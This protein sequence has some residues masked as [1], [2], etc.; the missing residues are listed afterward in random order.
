MIRH[1]TTVLAVFAALATVQPGRAQTPEQRYHDWASPTFPASEYEARRAAALGRL[2]GGVLLVPSSDGITHGDT[3][4]Q[5]DDFLYFTGLELP[6]SMLALDSDA[7]TV[8]LFLPPRDAR[9]ENPG[10]VNDFPGR[11]LGDDPDVAALSGITETR[12]V[13]VLPIALDTWVRGGSRLLVNAGATGPVEL[14]HPP[15][16]GSLDPIESLVMRVRSEFDG[17]DIGNAYPMLARLRM[18]KS[19]AEIGVMRRAADATAAGIR[20][21]A[22]AVGP[23]VDEATLQGIFEAT[24]R[25]HAAARIP[26]TPIVKSGPNSLWPWRILAAHSD[27]RNRTMGDGDVVILDVGCEVAGYVSDVGRSFP[28]SGRFTDVQRQKLEMITAVADAIIAAVRPGIRLVDLTNVA[29]DAIPDDEEVYMQTP[30]YFGHHIGLSSGDPALMDEIL[31]PGMVFT[32]EPWYYNH[33]LGVSLFVED[34]VLVTPEGAEVLTRTLPRSPD[35]LER[36]VR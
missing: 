4:R 11:P 3:F 36:M 19:P 6:G 17:V 33:D 22:S 32:V 20:S 21:T 15:W 8:T 35:N 27:R 24:C 18:R 12:P 16:V 13:D 31:A 9:F 30:S 1:T 26:F 25:E 5:L 29:Y 2:G 7:G 14:P 28:V 34:V 23:G 10:R